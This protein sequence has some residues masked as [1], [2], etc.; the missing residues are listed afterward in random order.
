M[1]IL[2]PHKM[3][4]KLR[5]VLI[6][7][8]KTCHSQP[9]P[10]K[11]QSQVPP[12][13]S[14]WVASLIL[15]SLSVLCGLAMLWKIPGF[16]VRNRPEGASSGASSVSVIIPAYNESRRLMPLLESLSTQT[17]QPLE[18]LVIDDHSTDGTGHLAAASGCQVILADPV[19]PGWV[20]KSRACWSG[21]KAARGSVL[22][23]LDADTRLEHPLA[24][25]EMIAAFARQGGQGILSVQPYHRVR[26][27]YES[28]STIFNIIVLAGLN[29][30]SILGDRI[31]GTGAFGPCLICSKD[32][33]FA[34]G[35]HQSIRAAV[36]DDLALGNLF[37]SHQ[38]PVACTSGR[39]VISFRMYPEGFRQLLEGW[40]KNFA[41]A[42]SSTHPLVLAWI[43]LWIGGGF[44]TA[45]VLTWA[46]VRHVPAEIFTAS[47]VCL[48]YLA[49]FLFQARRA[50]NFHWLALILY[51][52]HMLFFAA[53]FSWSVY[54]TKIRRSVS[55]RGRKIKV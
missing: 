13:G 46:L 7:S 28:F 25:S 11:F 52:L 45:A 34:T 26:K 44:S 41:T 20:G 33:Y 9:I 3:I 16:K 31:K 29:R 10:K 15:N 38:L 50:G 48:A 49:V 43:I 17:W 2:Y 27:V 35:G 30:F 19:E 14:M 6:K 4:R 40:T 54:L 21:A 5:T 51:P 47:L 36:L 1:N 12:G 37:F 55:W 23:F 39:G 18:I 53:L 32:A 42:S 22:V 8:P 24:L